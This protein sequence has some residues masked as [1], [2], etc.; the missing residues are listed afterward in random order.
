MRP[1]GAQLIAEFVKCSSDVL[2]DKDALEEILA[3]GIESC[4]MTL[5]GIN[6]HA[7]DPVGV[8][9]V[10]VIGESHAVIHTYPEARHAS[11]DIFTCSDGPVTRRDLLD[12]LGDQLSPVTMRVVDLGRG[13]PLEV[14]DADWITC[15]S[16]CGYETRYHIRKLVHSNRSRF[17]QIDIIENE[18][19][20]RMLFLDRDLQIADR[21]ASLYNSSLVSPIA[22]ENITLDRVAILGGGDGGVLSELLRHEP[23]SVVLVDIDGDVIEASKTHL[24]SICGDSFERPNVTVKIEDANDFLKRESGFDAIIYDLTMFP[25]A[26]TRSERTEFLSGI[27]SKI[28]KSL[29]PGGMVTMQCCSE[30]DGKTKELLCE[31]LSENFADIVFETT[32]I[33]SFCERWMFASARVTRHATTDGVSAPAGSKPARSIP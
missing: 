14:K 30:F 33:P 2:N 29:K 24:R 25:E 7:F 6:S 21:D 32:F 31:I 5:V 1:L 10:A 9:V 15:F 11:I 26:L 17:Q 16:E 19:F 18:N 20:G 23:G 4:G 22:R 3:R 28:S 12:Y 8:T 27:F 13:N